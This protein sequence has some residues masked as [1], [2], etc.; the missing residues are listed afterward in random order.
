MDRRKLLFTLG[1]L[2][3][4]VAAAS[5]ALTSTGQNWPDKP[6]R[7]ILSQPPGSGPDAM[8]RLIGTALANQLGQPI[9]I[10]NRPGGQNA[11]GAQ[12]AARASADG[13]T[14]YFATAAALVTNAFLFKS[15]PYTPREDFAPVGMVGRVP[16]AITVNVDSPFQSFSDLIAYARA[17]PGTLDVANEGPLTF[18]GLLTRIVAAQLGIKVHPVPYASV[19]SGITDTVGGQIGVLMSDA[20]SVM[21]LVQARRLRALAVTTAESVPGLDGVAPIAQVIPGF[22]FY[23]WVG[24]VAPAATPPAIIERLNRALDH[25]L[26]DAT[27]FGRISA[28]GP[29]IKG[30]GTPQEMKQMIDDEYVRWESLAKQIQI[31]SE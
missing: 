26:T 21:P 13:Y 12:A 8:A 29:I 16:F 27:V 6:I 14:F 10:D 19:G 22:D 23:G 5:T 15:L 3:M 31:G 24:L 11:I 30:A 2:P 28:I 25:V 18:G 1:G 7:F 4:T 9:V 17:N 20:P